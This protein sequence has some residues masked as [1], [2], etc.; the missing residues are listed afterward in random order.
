[1][2]ANHPRTLLDELNDINMQTGEAMSG[3]E[4]AKAKIA[5]HEAE[6]AKWKDTANKLKAKCIDLDAQQAT[7]L[8]KMAEA[9]KMRITSI[10]D[11][12]KLSPNDCM[13]GSQQVSHR[14][15]LSFPEFR[16]SGL[17]FSGIPEF[18]FSFRS[19]IPGTLPFHQNTQL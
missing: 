4:Q 7:V 6:I 1:M 2:Q 15:G 5:S 8:N 16:N 12:G 3:I 17:V 14:S 11:F 18:R 13:L 9:S 10:G 19:G